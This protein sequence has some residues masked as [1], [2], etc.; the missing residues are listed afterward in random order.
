M[1]PRHQIGA[2]EDF[3]LLGRDH[4]RDIDRFGPR[5]IKDRDSIG[6]IRIGVNRTDQGHRRTRHVVSRREEG[7]RSGC[8]PGDLW[9]TEV[10]F[11][12][13]AIHDALEGRHEKS[14]REVRIRVQGDD[15]QNRPHPELGKRAHGRRHPWLIDRGRRRKD[16]EDIGHEDEEE[17]SRQDDGCEADG[18]SGPVASQGHGR[19]LPA[20]GGVPV[21]G[22]PGGPAIAFPA[23]MP[24]REPHPPMPQGFSRSARL[25]R[26]KGGRIMKA[27]RSH[28]RGG[29]ETLVYE[30]GPEPRIGAGEALVR[31]HA[32]AITPTE[33]TWNSTWTDANGK[34]RRPI[35][36][37]FEVSGT[38]ERVGA[39]V[40]DMKQSEPVYGLL[41]FWRDGAA[42][43]LVAARAADL[44]PK[45][46][47]LDPVHAAAVPLSG[48]T[49]WQALFDHAGVAA[50]DRVLIHGA[51]GGVGTFAIQ[52]AHTRGAHV[53]GTASKRNVAFLEELGADEVVDYSSARFEDR[54]RGVD[55]VI[56]TVGG[57]TLDR[58]WGVLRPGGVLVTI[59][60]DAPETIAA[61]Y[62][63][64]G[65]SMLVQPNKAELVEIAGLI[66]AGRVRPVVDAVFPLP[67]AREGFERVLW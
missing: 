25:A 40:T 36:P 44:A 12:L 14:R 27:I 56:D 34:D 32:A 38:V 46:R 57:D 60:G 63:V 5:R 10:E 31:V 2:H 42:A 41:N 15:V 16:P 54:I 11:D 47:S 18:A 4:R 28:T 3:V 43:E 45:P 30:D 62:G 51:A 22:G 50:G 37:S 66:D 9:A 17:E 6:S 55:A 24:Q 39:G 64:R 13:F 52:F 59:A 8:V 19:S 35:V 49:A 29:P 67:Q 48:L 65:V 7:Q 53:I 58:S 61:K 20:G 26:G 23:V 1:E 21:D 33:L